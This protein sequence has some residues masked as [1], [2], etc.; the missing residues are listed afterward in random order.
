MQLFQTSS[1]SVRPT[2]RRD[3]DQQVW[4]FELACLLFRFSTALCV[5]YSFVDF[6][7]IDRGNGMQTNGY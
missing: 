6:G 4:S 2:R 3:V 5:E 7:A 1:S